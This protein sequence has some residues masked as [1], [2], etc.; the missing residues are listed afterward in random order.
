MKMLRRPDGALEIQTSLEDF[1]R[2]WRAARDQP[3][4]WR[5]LTDPGMPTRPGVVMGRD[6][7]D[8]AERILTPYP[9]LWEIYQ[10]ES[11]R[12]GTGLS[13]GERRCRQCGKVARP[14]RELA[15]AWIFRCDACHGLEHAAKEEVGGTLGQGESQTP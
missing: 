12:R 6:A 8:G 2:E 3:E 14:R 13:A 11:R 5:P 1:T 9:A 15:H 4:R 7:Y 10:H